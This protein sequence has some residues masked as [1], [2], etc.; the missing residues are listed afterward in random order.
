MALA[1]SL[2]IFSLLA[3]IAFF[4]GVAHAQ[5]APVAAPLSGTVVS[6]KTS[7]PIAG[8]MLLVYRASGTG[9]APLWQQLLTT[10]EL[11][12]YEL[13]CLPEGEYGVGVIAHGYAPQKTSFTVAG[14]K[15]VVLDFK[16]QPLAHVLGRAVRYD[17]KPLKSKYIKYDATQPNSLRSGV[18]MVLRGRTTVFVD[19]MTGTAELD[20][21]GRFVIP[22]IV[23]EPTTLL[24][25][26]REDGGALVNVDF[27]KPG[28]VDLGKVVFK[29]FIRITGKVV[30]GETGK[31]VPGARVLL[32]PKNVHGS[33]WEGQT[34]YRY[35]QTN[36]EGRFAFA[37]VVPHEYTVYA[38]TRNG[39][40]LRGYCQQTEF[41]TPGK[42]YDVT[43]TLS[44]KKE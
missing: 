10:D 29:P 26:T 36:S 42:A 5:P 22:N 7:E 27:E 30:N 44:K 33:L 2:R 15:P 34:Y 9:E 28:D 13:P 4:F 3:L 12:R 25:T 16:L 18:I 35:T 1:M 41:T 24:L 21:E 17:G 40:K 23:P 39:S 6:A 11:G 32:R 31:P 19:P 20:D 8:A 37:N 43:V 14:G 38:Y